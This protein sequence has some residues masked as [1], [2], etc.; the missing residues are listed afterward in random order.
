MV[1]NPFHA[2]LKLFFYRSIKKFVRL[3]KNGKNKLFGNWLIID[4]VIPIFCAINKNLKFS[5]IYNKVC[6]FQIY[7]A[8]DLQFYE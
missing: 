3:K 6:S 5:W 8:M 4:R 2:Q 7:I 1:L